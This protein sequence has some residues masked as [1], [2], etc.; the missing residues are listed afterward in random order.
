MAS[1]HNHLEVME[2]MP[3]LLL[4]CPAVHGDAKQS[5]V[6][7]LASALGRLS[8]H[9]TQVCHLGKSLLVY[10]SC[11]R[12]PAGAHATASGTGLALG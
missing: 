8:W 12:S 10:R 4:P 9:V 6:A 11:Q 2:T 3:Q 7:G 5:M 1:L